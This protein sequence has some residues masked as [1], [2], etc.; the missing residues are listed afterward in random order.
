MTTP[1]RKKDLNLYELLTSL[2]CLSTIMTLVVAITNKDALVAPIPQIKITK[3]VSY[4]AG[5]AAKQRFNS[6]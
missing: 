2:A 3:V 1:F 6:H 4:R 5:G